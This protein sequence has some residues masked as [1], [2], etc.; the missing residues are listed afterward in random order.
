MCY[1]SGVSGVWTGDPGE[2]GWWEG[3]L[4]KERAREELRGK[5]GRGG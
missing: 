1:V 5:R 4:G 2:R 3:F